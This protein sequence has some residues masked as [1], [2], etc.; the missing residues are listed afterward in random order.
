MTPMT[1]TDHLQGASIVF[2]LDGTLVDSAPDLTGALNHV[3]TLHGRAP[4]EQNAVRNLIG[5]GAAALIKAGMAA[6]GDPVE[7]ERLPDLLGTFLEHYEW[8]IADNSVPYAGVVDAIDHLRAAG[9]KLGV[10]TNKREKY[11]LALLKALEL[12]SRFHAILGADSLEVHKPDPGHL[13]GTIEKMGGTPERTIMIG[14]SETDVATAMAAN[15]PCIVVSFGYTT[16][17]PEELGGTLLIDHYDELLP[18]LE[19]LLIETA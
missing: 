6:T 13:L 19:T 18:A 7:E 10:C 4:I 16:T 17:P 1:R 14:D 12:E 2:D 11:A 3:L 5:H 9:A 15:I 8:H